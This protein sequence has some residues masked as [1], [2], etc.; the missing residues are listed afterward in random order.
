MT[1]S[2]RESN[3]DGSAPSAFSHCRDSSVE[4]LSETFAVTEYL[5]W[6]HLAGCVLEL[7]LLINEENQ[8]L[9]HMQ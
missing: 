1:K 7:K 5:D 2:T 9:I 3:V 4:T 8:I 6:F